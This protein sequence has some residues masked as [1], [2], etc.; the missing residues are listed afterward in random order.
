MFDDDGMMKDD[1][2]NISIMIKWE[3]I[4]ERFMKVDDIMKLNIKE[5]LV[6]IAYLETTNSKPPSK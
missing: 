1:K 2:P 3:V 6:K 4:Q 5:Q